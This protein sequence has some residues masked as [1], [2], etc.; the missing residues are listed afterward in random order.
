MEL[1][2]GVFRFH[3]IN[4]LNPQQR[5]EVSFGVFQNPAGADK[6]SGSSFAD[7]PIHVFC[8]SEA[9]T[10]RMNP[11]IVQRNSDKRI[12]C[13]VC[14]RGVDNDITLTG[15][16]MHH[17]TDI[18]Y[19]VSMNTLDNAGRSARWWRSEVFAKVENSKLEMLRYGS[20][21]STEDVTKCLVDYC[22]QTVAQKFLQIPSWLARRDSSLFLCII[23]GIGRWNGIALFD[24]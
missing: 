24:I 7:A 13:E 2:D 14:G 8:L 18:A 15:Q 21:F 20:N 22:T 11:R 23:L 16:E 19:F 4:T 3:L 9:W 5:T 17:T 6:I 10:S 1:V 12:A